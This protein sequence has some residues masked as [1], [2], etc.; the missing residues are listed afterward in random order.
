MRGV[1]GGAGQ[2]ACAALAV[3]GVGGG[4]GEGQGAAVV[5]GHNHP[6]HANLLTCHAL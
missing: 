3:R 6:R 5:T 1:R 2:R 4:A